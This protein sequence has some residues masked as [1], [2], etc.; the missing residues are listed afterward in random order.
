MNPPVHTTLHTPEIYLS[1]YL[2]RIYH[3]SSAFIIKGVVVWSSKLT[4]TTKYTHKACT[5][6]PAVR[7]HTHYFTLCSVLTVT[8]NRKTA[9]PSPVC[10]KINYFAFC[11]NDF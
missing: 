6:G 1:I 4:S 7:G 11:T 9:A 10:V 8:Q 5:N 3:M 2:Y